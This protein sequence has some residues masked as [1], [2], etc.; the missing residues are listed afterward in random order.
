MSTVLAADIGGTNIRAAVVKNGMIE[1]EIHSRIELGDRNLSENELIERLS[2]FFSNILDKRGD[3]VAI[4]AGFPGFFLGTSGHLV[5]SPNL[6]NLHQIDLATQLSNHLRIPVRIQND[7]LCAAIGE[8]RFGS[9]VGATNLLHVTLGTGIGGGLIL[10]NAPYTGE[11]GMAMEFGHLRVA[12]SEHARP[13]GCGGRGCVEAYAS[14]TAITERYFEVT[15][16]RISTEGI[17]NR[18]RNGD[19]DAKSTIESAGSY[20]GMAIAE[21]IKLL[22]I[23]TVTMSGGLT[24][25]WPLLH[26]AATKAM[27]DNLIPPLK[28]KVRILQSTLNDQAGI[29]GAAVLTV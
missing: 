25:A 11:S 5:A 9:G 13:C 8:H 7:A 15:G 24:G 18:A 2:A 17:Y 21:A 1:A 23:H 19:D 14:A 29:L 28:S 6:P 16:D 10:N 4:G 26:P 20:L 22:D 27:E 12:H 3:I